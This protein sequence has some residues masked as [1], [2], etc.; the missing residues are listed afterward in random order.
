MTIIFI[1]GAR[2]CATNY[3]GQHLLAIFPCPPVDLSNHLSLSEVAVQ[4]ILLLLYCQ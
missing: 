2:G 1:S 3:H 4:I